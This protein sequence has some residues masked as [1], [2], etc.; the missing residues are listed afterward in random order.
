MAVL[1]LGTK[2]ERLDL[3]IKQG[4]DLGPFDAFM[5]NPDGSP[6]NLTNC[7][8]VGRLRK[9][10]TAPTVAAVLDCE[11]VDALE[12]HYRFGLGHAATAAL[13]CGPKETDP[14]SQYYWDMELIDSLGRIIPLYYGNAPVFRNI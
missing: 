8:F 9:E 6:V 7:T 1:K 5:K 10:P 11:V 3:D 12:G 14:A 4:A 2:G 13:K